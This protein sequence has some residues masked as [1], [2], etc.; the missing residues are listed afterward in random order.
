M[1]WLDVLAHRFAEDVHGILYIAV[2][3]VAV[4]KMTKETAST[5]KC[6]MATHAVTPGG[7]GRVCEFLGE[8]IYVAHAWTVA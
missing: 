8:F 4:Y 7:E 6:T 3:C 1:N 5:L 2:I